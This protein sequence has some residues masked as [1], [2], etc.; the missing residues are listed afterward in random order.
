M[1]WLVCLSPAIYVRRIFVR[2]SFKENL[3]QQF[4]CEPLCNLYL[5]SR[6]YGFKYEWGLCIG[7][8]HSLNSHDVRRCQT[9]LFCQAHR[10]MLDN[11]GCIC[12]FGSL[13]LYRGRWFQLRDIDQA[14]EVLLKGHCR[15]VMRDWLCLCIISIL[16]SLWECQCVCHWT[17][18]LCSRLVQKNEC[19]AVPN[20]LQVVQDRSF[21]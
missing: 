3:N 7:H 15:V 21:G 4:P 12:N 1:V 9:S 19:I 2:I 13:I 11:H 17:S 8:H 20:Y 14:G 18:S 5:A 6:N 10:H 16:P